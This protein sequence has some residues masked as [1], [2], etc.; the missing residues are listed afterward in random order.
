MSE[1][2]TTD[3]VIFDNDDKQEVIN[4]NKQEENEQQDD[5]QE[6]EEVLIVIPDE[7][8]NI[9]RIDSN[10]NYELYKV[11]LRRFV[12]TIDDWDYNRK[13]N[14]KHI[15]ELKQNYPSIIGDFIV[16]RCKYDDDKLLLI[17]GQHRRDAIIELFQGDPTLNGKGY[18][19]VFNVETKNDIAMLFKK[20]NNVMPVNINE[21]PQFVYVDVIDK[22]QLKFPKAIKSLEKTKRVNFPYINKNE[23]LKQL[24]GARIV[25]DFG[26]TSTQLYDAIFKKNSEYSVKKDIF[27]NIKTP[28]AYEKAQTSGFYLGLD[29]NGI[30]ISELRL[31][32]KESK[33]ESSNEQPSTMKIKV[34]NNKTNKK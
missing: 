9:N 29:R 5:E 11:D 26:L 23:L 31:D 6:D 33:Q 34:K 22:L 7:I 25:E 2:Q 17:D 1:I 15:A 18:V 32:L 19:K 24:Q 21:I 20:I 28:G 10:D 3:F 30:W 12:S 16:V 8:S 13:K 4:E 14:Q 27:R